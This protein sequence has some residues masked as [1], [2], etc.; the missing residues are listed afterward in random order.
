MSEDSAPDMRL[1]RLMAV[2]SSLSDARRALLRAASI[3]SEFSVE[4]RALLLAVADVDRRVML[5][6]TT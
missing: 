6:L 4:L 2:D 5:K 3:E 1:T